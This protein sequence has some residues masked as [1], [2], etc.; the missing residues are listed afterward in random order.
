MM[1]SNLTTAN[2]LDATAAAAMATKASNFDSCAT[3]CEAELL[4]PM[5]GYA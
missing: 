4:T 2:S 5:S 3:L 1:L